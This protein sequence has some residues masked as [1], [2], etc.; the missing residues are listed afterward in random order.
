[1]QHTRPHIV[2]ESLTG[3]G[4][5]PTFTSAPFGTSSSSPP[6]GVCPPHPFRVRRLRL[7]ATGQVLHACTLHI[8]RYWLICML[9]LFPR[10]MLHMLRPALP[11][12][13][14]RYVST[15]EHDVLRRLGALALGVQQEE[16]DKQDQDR[17]RGEEGDD[18]GPFQRRAVHE[19]AR[20]RW[21]RWYHRPHRHNFYL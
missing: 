18:E 11:D 3:A 9:C 10:K 20:S 7:L 5:P 8:Q 4:R 21:G 19:A 13:V 1:M 15:H 2:H 6:S 16:E 14:C 17:D 12:R